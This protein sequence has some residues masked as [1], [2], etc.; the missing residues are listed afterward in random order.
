MNDDEWTSVNRANWDDRARAHAR[1]PGEFYD[2]AAVRAGRSSL[3]PIETELAGDVSGR[4]LLH[5]M[6][7]LGLDSISW[8]RHGARVTAM[9]SSPVAIREARRLASELGVA[10]E[11]DI[12]DVYDLP[13]MYET[14]FG[15]I[16]MTYGVLPW[17]RDLP[18]FMRL[19]AAAM[20]PGG[21]FVLVDGHPMTALW[22]YESARGPVSALAE[23]YFADPV[24]ARR[25][26]R[27]SY[28]G[29]GPLTHSVSYQW[30]HHVAEILQAVIGAG[31]SLRI[32]REERYGFYRR[33]A[34]MV[35]RPD[36]YL[37]LPAGSPQVP[38][39]LALMAE[40]A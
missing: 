17:L 35:C 2:H 23:S 38:L 31:L 39:L 6:C 18:L 30:Q 1:T 21:R 28:G 25:D 24:P 29:G 40:R 32:V 3:R 20:E 15:V 26:R 4:P 33:Y 10:V 8:A 16:V 19:V 13:D 37:D 11:F 36:G 14:T 27:Q 12:G 7:H 34:G 9:D 5:L 22:P